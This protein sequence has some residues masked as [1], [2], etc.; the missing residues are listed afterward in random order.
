WQRLVTDPLSGA[1]L[2]VG[3]TSYR[4]PAAIADFV[5]LRDRTCVG[6][7]CTVPARLCQLD[8]VKPWHEG[9]A[10]S[11][12]NL[13]PDCGRDHVVKST[14]AFRVEHLGS[15]TF[16]WT[17]PSGHRYRREATGRITHV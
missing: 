16:E 6:V 7:G 12:D 8:H 10:T 13:A 11:T 9:G 2:D 1:L 3:R 17:T 4:P 5:R 15:G 14:G